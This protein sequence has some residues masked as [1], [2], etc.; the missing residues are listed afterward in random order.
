[1]S[2]FTKA[3]IEKQEERARNAEE[4]G[5]KLISVAEI[6]SLLDC[7]TAQDWNDACDAIKGVRGGQY[8]EDWFLQV[9]MSG[10][11]GTVTARWQ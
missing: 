1:M 2:Y 9:N 10:L 11:M 8:P 6:Q 4:R 7:Q 5:L 3:D